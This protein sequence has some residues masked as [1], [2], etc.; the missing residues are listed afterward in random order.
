MVEDFDAGLLRDVQ[1]LIAGEIFKDFLE[2]ADHLLENNYKDAAASL[3]GAVLEDGLRRIAQVG[4]VT[5]KARDEV[6]SLNQRCADAG[7]YN[8][9]TQKRLQVWVDVRNNADHGNFREYSA[10]DVKEMIS[11]VTEFLGSRVG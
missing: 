9:L 3:T 8:R 7:L 1:E 11:G 6:G 10:N 5:V 2:M 4:G